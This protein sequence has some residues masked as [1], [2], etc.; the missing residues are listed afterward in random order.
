MCRAQEP[1]THRCQQK[2]TVAMQCGHLLQIH[3]YDAAKSRV[4]CCFLPLKPC[5]F[6]LLTS[7]NGHDGQLVSIKLHALEGA[8]NAA[9]QSAQGT[10]PRCNQCIWKKRLAVQADATLCS[11]AC[12]WD[13]P[14]GH[15]CKKRCGQCLH[16]TLQSKG[17]NPAGKSCQ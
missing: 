1:H 8:T 3:C 16:K 5:C 17:L 13:L 6:L 11:A 4:C 7:G 2:V 14:C 12:G 15:A 10:Q 9:S